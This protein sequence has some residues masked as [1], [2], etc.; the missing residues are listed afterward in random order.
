MSIKSDIKKLHR[1]R[2]Q[3]LPE[4]ATGH[5]QNTDSDLTEYCS[6]CDI[7]GIYRIMVLHS[8]GITHFQL[9]LKLCVPT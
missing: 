6:V 7:Y 3:L 9:F 4:Y 1:F 2:S 8:Y 5:F